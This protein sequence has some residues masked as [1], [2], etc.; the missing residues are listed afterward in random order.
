[1]LAHRLVREGD[2]PGEAPAVLA[3]T[4]RILCAAIA[5]NCVPVAVGL[6]LTIRRDLKGK[7]FGVLKRQAAVQTETRNAHDSELHCQNIAFL[8]ARI[9]TGRLVNG[10]YFAIGKRGG[11]EV[12]RLNGRLC[13]PK[14]R[15]C[16]FMSCAPSAQL[17]KR[18]S[19]YLGLAQSET[20]AAADP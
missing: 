9:V 14:D 7:S 12:C 19:L 16:D 13:R 6:F 11:V 4:A 2:L 1:M 10:G 17:G 5:Y 3:P 20:S 15:S 8:T 18:P